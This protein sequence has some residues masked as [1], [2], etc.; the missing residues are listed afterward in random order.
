MNTV[1]TPLRGG[2]AVVVTIVL[3]INLLL[4]A[5]GLAK[6]MNSGL[7]ADQVTLSR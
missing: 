3:A 4:Q 6:T 5:S 1:G 2:F 7:V